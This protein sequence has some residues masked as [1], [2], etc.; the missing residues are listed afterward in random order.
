MCQIQ[1]GRHGM[2]WFINNQV[3]LQLYIHSL[4][5]LF[6]ILYS[7]VIHH[8]LH[9]SDIGNLFRIMGCELYNMELYLYNITYGATLCDFGRNQQHL[10]TVYIL[11]TQYCFFYW[12]RYYE[13]INSHS[14]VYI[15]ICCLVNYSVWLA[16]GFYFEFS[17]LH[18]A[19]RIHCLHVML[20]MKNFMEYV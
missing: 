5:Q 20:L 3:R 15:L 17:H 6:I 16:K 13:N 4:A 10:L 2:Y 12:I 7:Y 14:F 18:N 19:G 11:Y 9:Y 8:I 1:Y